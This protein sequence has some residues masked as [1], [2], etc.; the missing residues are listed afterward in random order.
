M[1]KTRYQSDFELLR[2]KAEALLK[3]KALGSIS[4]V[5][6]ADVLKLIHELEV[7]DIEL[8][9]QNEELILARSKAQ[10][11]A[12]KYIELYD[13][14]PT[15]YYTFDFDSKIV[16]LNF[17]GANLLGKTRN[18]LKNTRFSNFVSADS[19]SVFNQFLRNL[20]ENETKVNCEITLLP[21]G[22]TQ[23][24]LH[25]SGVVTEDG[26]LCQV[27]A[28]D[29]TLLKQTELELIDAKAKAEENNRLKS[30]FL[31]NMSHEIR[32]PMNGILG[33]AELLKEPLLQPEIQE[34]YIDIINKSGHH[35][36]TV[37][38]NII[39]ISRIE[40]GQVE[41]SVSEFNLND[42]IDYVYNFF[43]P[44][45]EK[46]GIRLFTKNGL[47]DNK[48]LIRTDRDKVDSVLINLVKNAIK[49]TEVGSIE[50]GYSP[51]E[52]YLEFFVKDTGPG[53]NQEQKEN[54]FERFIK[55]SPK[56]TRNYEGSGL[57]LSIA[58]AYV[59]LL[60]GKIWVESELGNGSIF[61]FSI[62]FNSVNTGQADN[63]SQQ[64]LQQKTLAPLLDFKIL[65][66][67]R[68]EV[69][70][71]LIMD[72]VKS[73]SKET[74]TVK[75]G[76]EV[77]EACRNHPDFDLVW[78]DIGMLETDAYE[79]ARKIRRFDREAIIIART[80]TGT[81]GDREKALR[82]GYNDY[83]PDPINRTV[84]KRLLKKHFQNR[85]NKQSLP[86]GIKI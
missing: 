1:N 52:T 57:G 72:I 56:F 76:F 85:G 21:D 4:P 18:E 33:F 40:S 64:K 48:A 54:I 41:L 83:V 28:V 46:K 49:F 55:Y 73:F 36:L 68:N 50:I 67:E 79:V 51:K 7:H 24:Y 23:S 35:L 47:P 25:L 30:A 81:A 38:N 84:L 6:E 75:S 13:F 80:A 2:Q 29:I 9:L 71:R 66:A 3:T 53:I 65:I 61:Y 37:I 26:E 62:P 32:T 44:E 34:H 12:E 82:A 17:A 11:A 10:K 69:T 19:K 20:F 78:M 43:N 70:E 59:E 15:G 8:E 77:M 27:N 74:I 39:S 31:A 16:E 5:S 60:G 14:A 45:T 22:S 86:Q 58:K 42:L 63:K